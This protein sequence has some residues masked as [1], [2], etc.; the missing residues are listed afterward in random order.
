MIAY[1]AYSKKLTSSGK[2]PHDVELEK[3]PEKSMEGKMWLMGDVSAL[4]HVSHCTEISVYVFWVYRP[5][6]DVKPAKDII[7]DMVSE[8][9][10]CLESG[11][12]N[13]AG[14]PRAKL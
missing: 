6:Q 8:A 7:E 10:K 11:A 12:G 5:M 3:H 4:I 2:I 13:V 9:K 1:S 14:G